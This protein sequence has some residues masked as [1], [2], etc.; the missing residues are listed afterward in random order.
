M[1]KPASAIASGIALTI[2]VAALT[3]AIGG[4]PTPH[5]PARGAA[6]EQLEQ[7]ATTQQ[8]VDALRAARQAG[9]FGAR[10]AV[11]ASPAPGWLGE[12]PLNPTT[13]DWEPA[14]AADPNEPWV[15]VLATRYG[16]P[17]PCPGNCP[18]P[19]IVLERS[20]DGGRTWTEGVPLC[21]CKGSGQFDPII[22]VV[23]GTG[24]VY[25]IFMNG[26][27]VVF[28]K[29]TNHGRT[30]SDPVPTYGKVSW[31]DKPVL[32]T[33]PDGRDVYVSWNG[34]QGGDP[35]IA[36][37]HDAG[38]T[39]SQTK[40]VNS[41]R[42]YFAFDASV[43]PDGTVVFSESSL[44]YT[45]P[46]AD[47]EGVVKQHALISTDRGRTWRNVV[48]DSG[49]VGEPCADC[50]ADYYLGHSSVSSN[51]DG[52][53]IYTYDLASRAL[54]PQRIYVRRSSDGGITWSGRTPLSEAGENATAPAVE[55][56]GSRDVR[57]FYFQT[58]NGDDPDLWNVWY[59]TSGNGGRTWSSPSRISDASNGA[60][61]KTPAGF[62]EPYGDYGE[63]A[64][65]SRGNTVAAWGEGFSWLGP[66]GVWINVQA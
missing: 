17:K 48:V 46:G 29:S 65:T 11:H 33:G 25:A 45:A 3:I 60:Q 4:S 61:Y 13:D 1:R 56:A 55:Y 18:T 36:V 40:A 43:L 52:A 7:T 41:K 24:H 39:W 19:W 50:R 31:N 59:R 22:E 28:Q 38:E 23:P 27:N 32:N 47:P 15:Y 6:A 63:I 20:S 2:V 53:L 26:Y 37:S 21:A 49:P 42:Y 8:R 58:A 34:P 57:L 44:T 62:L 64:I 10:E 51:L 9:L 12:R 35:W 5:S 30:W 14:I 16:E 66:G 54:G